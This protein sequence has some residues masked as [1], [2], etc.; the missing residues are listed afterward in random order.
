MTE[1]PLTDAELDEMEAYCDT[2]TPGPWE[3]EETWSGLIVQRRS[4]DRPERKPTKVARIYDRFRDGRIETWANARFLA[5]VRCDLPRLLREY[6]AA[7]KALRV[8]A[9][10]PYEWDLVHSGH[11]RVAIE[12]ARAALKGEE[13]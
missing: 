6:R 4:N 2:G 5:Q 1:Q 12:T 8:I 10:L 11:A 7:R 9:G 3:I 13:G